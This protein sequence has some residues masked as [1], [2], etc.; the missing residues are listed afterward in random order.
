MKNSRNSRNGRRSHAGWKV[1]SLMLLFSGCASQPPAPG[2]VTKTV[3]VYP[4]DLLYQATPRPRFQGRT[5]EDLL[6]YTERLE[7]ALGSCNADKA[8]IASWVLSN[9]APDSREP[10]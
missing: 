2:V 10:K 4:P 1:L 5:N 7:D 9:P 6:G 3:R 8:S